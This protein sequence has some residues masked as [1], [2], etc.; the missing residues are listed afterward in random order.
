MTSIECVSTLGNR[1]VSRTTGW[2]HQYVLH[3]VRVQQTSYE[4]DMFREPQ[5][6]RKIACV[7]TQTHTHTRSRARV[8]ADWRAVPVVRETR[9][10]HKMSV[11]LGRRHCAAYCYHNVVCCISFRPCITGTKH[12]IWHMQRMPVMLHLPFLACCDAAALP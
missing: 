11:T 3:V 4:S 5:V 6:F 10:L 12:L 9:P 1:I 8:R 2:T 7:H